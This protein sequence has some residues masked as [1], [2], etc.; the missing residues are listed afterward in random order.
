MGLKLPYID[1]IKN[2]VL[3]NFS[4]LNQ[5]TILELG[6]QVVRPGQGIVENT[7]KE[8]WTNQGMIHTSVDLNGMDG[9]LIKDLTRIEDFEEFTNSFDVVYNLGTTEHVEPF[10]D[11]YTVFK[12]IDMCC[13]PGSIMIHGVPEVT[14]HDKRNV[15]AGHCHY[16]YSKEFFKTLAEECNYELLHLKIS[17]TNIG[18]V[19]KK[20]ESSSFN[21]EK[22]KLLSNIAIRNQDTDFS[23]NADYTYQRKEIR[24]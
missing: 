13:K 6:N 9:A 24:F 2:S 1:L 14:N 20:T 5:I 21:I 18:C 8:Y 3:E 17:S 10:E 15:W 4:T 19:L 23:S 22:E 12:I 7:G 11:Q 16:Y